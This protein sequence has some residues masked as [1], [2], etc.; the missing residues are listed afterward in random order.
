MNDQYNSMFAAD[1]YAPQRRCP[2]HLELAPPHK[3]GAGGEGLLTAVHGAEYH[4][5]REDRRD[6]LEQCPGEDRR[7]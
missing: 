7:A 2:G 3:A 4:E 6:P 1:G 5:R